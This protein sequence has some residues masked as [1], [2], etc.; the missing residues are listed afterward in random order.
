MDPCTKR[1]VP[2]SNT[3]P[4]SRQLCQNLLLPLGKATWEGNQ[5]WLILGGG[6][7]FAAFPPLYAVSFSGF[8]LAMLAPCSLAPCLWCLRTPDTLSGAPLFR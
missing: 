6:A 1:Q 3:S 5:V 4:L 7:I 2:E 8:Y